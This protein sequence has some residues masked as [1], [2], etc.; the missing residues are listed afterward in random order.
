MI[1]SKLLAI[2]LLFTC[3]VSTSCDTDSCEEE[4]PIISFDN[5]DYGI[6]SLGDSLF[7]DS[8]VIQIKFE[9]CQGD[10]GI[11]EGESGFNLHTYQYEWVNEEWQRVE[12][13][14]PGDTL[15]FFAK[16]PYSEK[17]NEGN[18]LEGMIEQ[19][20][21]SVKQRGDSIYFEMRL[22]DRAGNRSNLLETPV[23]VLQDY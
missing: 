3:V 8:L 13:L 16:V 1:R 17:I 10:I 6:F 7:I 5:Y 22:F 11:K 21:G 20:F 23:F 14:N 12:P 19:R 4:S 18:R 15:A 9:D 2:L